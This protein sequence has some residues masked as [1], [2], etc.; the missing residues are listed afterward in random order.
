VVSITEAVD[1]PNSQRCRIDGGLEFD[2][3]V[4]IALTPNGSQL[5]VGARATS[6]GFDM[7]LVGRIHES[8]VFSGKLTA[9]ETAA[10]E[11]YAF[12]RYGMKPPLAPATF[13]SRLQVASERL[14]LT[15]L[16]R[17]IAIGEYPIEDD[18]WRAW[19]FSEENPDSTEW[20]EYLQRAEVF[21]QQSGLRY[22]EL[23]ELLDTAFVRRF[24]PISEP[25]LLPETGT[26]GSQVEELSIQIG[27]PIADAWEQIHRF[28]R[29][30][31]RL[32]WAIGDFDK[33]VAG[34]GAELDEPLIERLADVL[35]L[36]QRFARS[37]RAKCP[38][39]AGAPSTPTCFS[40]GPSRTPSSTTFGGPRVFRSSCPAAF[41]GS[42]RMKPR[43]RLGRI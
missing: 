41:S 25:R 43:P 33:I 28:L 14:G 3:G 32:G 9:A 27:D 35:E 24:A 12:E 8:A 10:L 13:P 18:V 15:D 19:G 1:D 38:R 17:R 22:E 23:R 11:D 7:F 2:D 30:R 21:L 37:T 40:V 26:D 20:F 34:L 4:S 6:G 5:H 39:S 36:Q 31:L 42:G 29:L 16:G